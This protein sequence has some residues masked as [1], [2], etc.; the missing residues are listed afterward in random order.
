MSYMGQISYMRSRSLR[1][2]RRLSQTVVRNTLNTEWFVFFLPW[3]S[4]IQRLIP[5]AFDYGFL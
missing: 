3:I 4:R 2:L 5:D 1:E